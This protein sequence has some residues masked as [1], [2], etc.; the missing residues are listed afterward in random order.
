MYEIHEQSWADDVRLSLPWGLT[1]SLLTPSPPSLPP[2]F[3]HLKVVLLQPRP[4]APGGRL[5]GNLRLW[6]LGL[7]PSAIPMARYVCVCVC[8]CY[9]LFFLFFICPFS[10][11]SPR[12]SVWKSTTL[13]PWT[14]SLG[15][16]N[17]VRLD[18]FLLFPVR[19]LAFFRVV[20]LARSVFF[21]TYLL[22]YTHTHTHTH[23]SFLP[24]SLSPPSKQKR[25]WSKPMPTSPLPRG[26]LS[27]GTTPSTPLTPP[28]TP[29]PPSLPSSIPSH[30]KQRRI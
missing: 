3:P 11:F 20:P 25:T 28:L 23:I 17:G 9:Q 4:R 18:A 16:T 14:T 1:H 29:L 2:S 13:G 26:S 7:H 12:S 10:R 6:A 19:L 22:T 15:N 8:V 24:P 5:H 21:I 30:S 27:T